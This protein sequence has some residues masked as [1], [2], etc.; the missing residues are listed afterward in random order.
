MS[1][2]SVR[3]SSVARSPGDGGGCSRSLG[4]APRLAAAVAHDDVDHVA[5]ASYAASQT[6]SAIAPRENTWPACSASSSRSA[7]SLAVSSRVSPRA[8][9]DARAVDPQV[10]DLDDVLRWGGAAPEESSD[11]R[12]E[13]SNEN[14]L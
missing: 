4:L 2:C 8:R 1:S 14:G 11:P 12:Q 13:L 3:Q 7:N 10:A 6:C 9:L 5:L